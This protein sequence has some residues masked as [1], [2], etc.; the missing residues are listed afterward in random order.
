MNIIRIQKKR[1]ID[2]LDSF[3]FWNNVD[4]THIDFSE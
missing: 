1:S 2:E 3:C 4:V